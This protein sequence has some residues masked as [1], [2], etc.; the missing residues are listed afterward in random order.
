MHNPDEPVP[1]PAPA[2]AETEWFRRAFDDFYAELYAHRDDAEAARL[3]E[4]LR[5]RFGISGL[6][7]DVACG[8]GRF[9]RALYEARPRAVGCDLSWPLLRRARASMRTDPPG[10]FRADMRRIPV[11]SA[12]CAWALLVFT[13]F[14]YFDREEEDRMVLRELHRVL[15]LGGRL[16]FDFLNAQTA[17]RGLVPESQR[18]V[19][20]RRVREVRWVDASGPFLRKRIEA[21]AH[22]PGRPSF[23][24][25]E[26]VRLYT[27]GQLHRILD[28]AGFSVAEVWGDYS[29]APFAPETSARCVLI[30]TR[31][32]RA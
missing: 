31:G 12:A 27:P 19:A 21:A 8:P 28:D 5:R 18:E 7:L 11:R 20:G 6:V 22:D 1:G 13:S 10:L 4:T 14:G 17:V 26:R 15:K 2:A 32:D 16:A 3:V 23:V 24:Y 29:G 25:E 30:C 9:L